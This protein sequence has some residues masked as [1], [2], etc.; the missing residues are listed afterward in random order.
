MKRKTIKNVR[1]ET[2]GYVDTDDNGRSTA[3]DVH[4]RMVGRY[5]S[6]NDLTVNE[7]GQLKSHGDT[8]TNLIIDD[9]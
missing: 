8:L 1:G 5:N 2:L 6:D 9:D 7:K 4:G 3:K